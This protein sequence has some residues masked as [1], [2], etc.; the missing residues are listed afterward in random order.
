MK[1]EESQAEGI[2]QGLQKAVGFADREHIKAISSRYQPFLPVGSEEKK[3]YVAELWVALSAMAT[4]LH[5]LA[6]L[7]CAMKYGSEMS[8]A[9]GVAIGIAAGFVY[10]LTFYTG[11]YFGTNRGK[12]IAWQEAADAMK[13]MLD[14][15]KSEIAAKEVQP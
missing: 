8:I 1:T 5:I 6:T 9:A 11:H 15:V 10:F 4:C 2:R 7:R 14:E 12:E 13:K 3:S